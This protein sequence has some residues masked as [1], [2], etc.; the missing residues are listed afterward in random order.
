MATGKSRIKRHDRKIAALSAFFKDHNALQIKGRSYFNTC[1]VLIKFNIM[2]IGGQPLD[3]NG[4][5]IFIFI[6]EVKR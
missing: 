1:S 6:N 3:V 4:N 2:T 5:R